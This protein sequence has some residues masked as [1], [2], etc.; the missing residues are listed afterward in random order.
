MEKFFNNACPVNPEKHYCVPLLSRLGAEDVL[1]YIRWGHYFI[2]H[3]PR[4]MGKT[5]A[6][7]ELQRQINAGGEFDCLY[8][9]VEGA[10]VYRDDVEGAERRIIS[11]IA[12]AA[13]DLFGGG[14]HLQILASLGDHPSLQIAIKTLS[15]L[16]PK[17]VVLFIDEIDSLVGDS[18]ITVLRQLRAGYVHRPKLFPQSVILCGIRR[19][20]DYRITSSKHDEIITGGS[21][22]NIESESLVMTNFTE[23]QTHDLLLQHQH[24][25]HPQPQQAAPRVH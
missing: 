10:Q 24:R 20:R 18:L 22:F 13:E 16:R 19:V 6:L 7:L 2:V 21:C 17:P 3:A 25:Q 4:Q 12:D 5:S 14:I 15:E 8:V 23:G 9:N 1:R 11:I